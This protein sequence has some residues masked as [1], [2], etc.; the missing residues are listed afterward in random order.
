MYRPAARVDGRAV[1]AST[2]VVTDTVVFIPPTPSAIFATY[3]DSATVDE[4]PTFWPRTVLQAVF[5]PLRTDADGAYPGFAALRGRLV[6]APILRAFAD[7]RAPEAVRTWVDEIAQWNFDRVISSHFASPV[8]AT[9]EDV[10]AAF[11]YLENAGSFSRTTTRGVN[12]LPPIACQHWELLEGLNQVI[13]EYKLGAPAVFA[14]KRD[15]R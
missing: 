3:F 12:G 1:D 2:L 14:Y 10:R 5:L 13:A 15:C 8:Q 6:R 7:A 11:A 4:D 9:P